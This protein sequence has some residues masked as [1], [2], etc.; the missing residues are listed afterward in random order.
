MRVEREHTRARL[1]LEE[2][3]EDDALLSLER[4]RQR[5]VGM[6]A[7]DHVGEQLAGGQLLGLALTD[8]RLDFCTRGCPGHYHQ[9]LSIK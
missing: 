5:Q 2:H 6:E 1:D 8:E 9:T 3:V 7:L 4:A